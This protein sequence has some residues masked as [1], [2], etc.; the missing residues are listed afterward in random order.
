M[1]SLTIFLRF[2]IY[3]NNIFVFYF[4]VD[5]S[6]CPYANVFIPSSRI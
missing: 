2:L 6:L 4:F 1:F 3:N 5:M